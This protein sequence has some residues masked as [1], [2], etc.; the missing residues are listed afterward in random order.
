MRR[1]NND[2]R[3]GIYGGDDNRSNW[4]HGAAL[5]DRD[6][7]KDSENT[8]FDFVE[9]YYKESSVPL[10]WMLI[11]GGE[12]TAIRTPGSPTGMTTLTK[13]EWNKLMGNNAP[14]R[15]LL[16]GGCHE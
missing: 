1:Y 3:G 16:G 2:K 12:N 4:M 9:E 13:R 5:C 14:Q 15:N 7:M 8:W 6:N 11:G 10:S